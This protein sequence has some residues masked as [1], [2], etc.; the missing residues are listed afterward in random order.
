MTSFRHMTILQINASYYDHKE[1]K[2][3]Y[4]ADKIYARFN[5][6]NMKDNEGVWSMIMN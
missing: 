5:I 1:M 6:K 4:E 2:S 3:I